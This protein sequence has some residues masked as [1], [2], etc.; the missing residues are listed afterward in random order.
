MSRAAL[1]LPLLVSACIVIP[2]GAHYPADDLPVTAWP[3]SA[4]CPVPARSAG[5]ART[6]VGLIN[7]QRAAAGLGPLTLSAPLSEIAQRHACDN[8]AR[9]TV[10]HDGSDGSDLAQRLRRG[11]IAVLMAAENTGLGFSSPRIALDW[12]MASPPHRANILHPEITQIGIGQADGAPR[13]TWVLDFM[14]P[15]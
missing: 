7:A 5:D 15:R 3:A 12:W 13:P 4:A 14:R 1:L 10:S 11:G 9:Q 8:A 2:A 6:L